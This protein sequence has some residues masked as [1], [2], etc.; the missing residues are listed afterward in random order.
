MEWALVLP[1]QVRQALG[2]LEIPKHP[3]AITVLPS[4]R[5]QEPNTRKTGSPKSNPSQARCFTENKIWHLHNAWKAKEVHLCCASIFT[6]L[7]LLKVSA[8]YSSLS[9]LNSLLR[10]GEGIRRGLEISLTG[11]HE[12]GEWLKGHIPSGAWCYA[13]VCQPSHAI[14]CLSAMIASFRWAFVIFHSTRTCMTV[15]CFISPIRFNTWKHWHY[16]MPRSCFHYNGQKRLCWL[17]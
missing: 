15:L 7:E 8:P 12:K 17:S 6:S 3:G 11:L 16:H 2:F 9:R 13:T 5:A 14:K 4:P 1:Q 10:S